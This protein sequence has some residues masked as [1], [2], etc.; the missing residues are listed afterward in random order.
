MVSIWP[1]TAARTIHYPTCS[2]AC[3][4]AWGLSRTGSRPLRVRCAGSNS[5]DD[6][7]PDLSRRVTVGPQ[8]LFVNR[9]RAA[10]KRVRQRGLAGFLEQQA[11][12]R[13]VGRYLSV[14]RSV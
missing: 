6:T 8:L 5:R 12:I 14:I 10:E 9:Q 13:E 4:S 2:S 11:E 3:C 7:V 1:S